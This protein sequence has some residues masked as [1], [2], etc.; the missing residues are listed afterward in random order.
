MKELFTNKID[1]NTFIILKIG[2]NDYPGSGHSGSKG[3]LFFQRYIDVKQGQKF[4]NIAISPV[5]EYSGFMYPI[6]MIKD[7][8]PNDLFQKFSNNGEKYYIQDAFPIAPTDDPKTNEILSYII[9]HK[10]SLLLLNAMGGYCYNI[11]KYIL[12]MRIYPTGYGGYVDNSEA[13]SCSF[14]KIYPNPEQFCRGTTTP[15]EEKAAKNKAKAAKNNAKVKEELGQ[16]QTG[17]K[18]ADFIFENEKQYIKMLAQAL[19]KKYYP[20]KP[21]LTISEI[22]SVEYKMK[23]DDVYTFL[24]KWNLLDKLKNTTK[25]RLLNV[26]SKNLLNA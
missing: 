23:P 7:Y 26:V 8:R 1:D 3:Q 13:A 17:N 4:I 5:S 12:D 14:Q 19:M 2:S 24:K 11:F 6:E 20:D 16:Y 21:F 10:G 22:R 18:R 9:N 15:E 25:K